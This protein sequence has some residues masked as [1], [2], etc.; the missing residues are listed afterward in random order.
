[1]LQVFFFKLKVSPKTP[2]HSR[3]HIGDVII[4]ID[5]HDV[6]TWSHQ[7]ASEAIKNA[8]YTLCLLIRK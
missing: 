8:N 7:K 3:L 6:Q 4:G 2:A 5:G 1:V